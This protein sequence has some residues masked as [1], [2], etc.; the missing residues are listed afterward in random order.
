ML[1]CFDCAVAICA[2]LFG[3]GQ[4]NSTDVLRTSE[5]IKSHTVGVTVFALGISNMPVR[6]LIVHESGQ[7]HA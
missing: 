4:C 5:G 7:A 3:A 2:A 1:R 6:T